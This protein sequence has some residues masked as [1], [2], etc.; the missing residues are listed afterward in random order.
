MDFE[1]ACK[2]ILRDAGR[3]RKQYRKTKNGG[4]MVRAN[5]LAQ[6]A[7]RVRASI[8]SDPTEQDLK[9]IV[10]QLWQENLQR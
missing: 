3:L 6:L 10:D 2:R 7:A 9:R 4:L 5:A 8:P 1:M